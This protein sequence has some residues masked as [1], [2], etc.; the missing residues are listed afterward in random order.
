VTL[1][2][3]PVTGFD[4]I[5]FD[6]PVYIGNNPIV[7]HGITWE[8][9]KWAFIG[10]YASNWHPLTWISHMIDV[11]LFGMKP[12]MFHLVNVFF[13]ILNSILL[14]LVLERMTGA[15]WRSFF[16]AVLFALHPLHVESV[17]WISERKDVLS[18]FFWILTMLGYS[19][20]VQ[21]PN[22]AGY[23]IVIALFG[24]GLLAKPM[25]VTLPFVLLLLD[26][27]P[28]KRLSYSTGSVSVFPSL[29]TRGR[30]MG[31]KAVVGC[32]SDKLRRSVISSKET[33]RLVLEKIPLMIMALAAS[34]ETFYAQSVGGA[35]NTLGRVSIASRIQNS[36]ISYG[37]YL[38]KTIWPSGLAVF[39][40][41]PNKF[42]MITV[43][44]CL[45][46]LVAVCIMVIMY[47]KKLPYLLTG[48]FWYLG[49]LVPVIGF[50][51]VGSQSMAD[52]Y[53]YIP[54]IGIF[55]IVLWGL[56]DL[57]TRWT[58]GWIVLSVVSVAILGCLSAV[59]SVQ[60]A[61]WE[62]SETV[63]SHAL[64]VTKD[65]YL[66]HNC[67]GVALYGRDE[68]ENAIWHYQESVRINPNNVNAQ[69]NL[70][71]AL[72]HKKQYAEAFAHYR[73]CLRLKPGYSEAYYNMGVAFSELG[74]NDEAIKQY[75]AVLKNYPLHE[76][77]N[78]NLG[79]LL[80]CKGNFNEAIP[81]YLKSL[82]SNPDN[83]RTR[84]N[85]S[86]ALMEKRRYN[87]ALLQVNEA[88]KIN[89]ADA[90][91]YVKLAEIYNKKNSADQAF[92]AYQKALAIDPKSTR[93]LWGIVS[94]YSKQ[95]RFDYALGLLSKIAIIRP[96]DPA[97]DY[98]IAC[99]YSRMGDTG[100]AVRLLKSAISKGF[101]DW[102]TFRT[103]PDLENVRNTIYYREVVNS[104]L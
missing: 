23:I 101:K 59:T 13:H 69:C 52:R 42:N 2:Y 90:S 102:K 64:S 65:N 47:A 21:C 17:A 46:F 24:I 19:R 4:F 73:E 80:A 86:D 44:T 87:E 14:F 76:N 85:L 82:E 88:I 66:A 55:I 45:L 68:V 29:P 27:W 62:N 83:V 60:V 67:L 71:V 7:R 16:V 103:D 61:T 48:W 91:L 43:A 35:V 53:T 75:Q 18:T 41:Y 10:V 39:Y 3:W 36:I 25:L 92:T 20:Y 57:I 8:G 38:W 104:N 31:N 99:L 81:Y 40:P 56:T 93:A 96:S 84:T 12:G 97:V 26:F 6:D 51:Q 34:I 28:L 58:H 22:I 49:T 54:L 32:S 77:A 1:I 78:N 74:K 72:A 95:G 5:N 33:I 30:G 15:F 94:I 37:A 79:F 50:V 98:N 63:F 70:G 89:P 11:N 100:E 9:I